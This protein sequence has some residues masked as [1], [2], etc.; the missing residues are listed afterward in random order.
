MTEENAPR[1]QD[2]ASSTHARTIAKALSVPDGT[3]GILRWMSENGH[4]DVQ[5]GGGAV[6]PNGNA[7]AHRRHSGTR[8]KA[9]RFLSFSVRIT[10]RRARA[11]V[12][13]RAEEILDLGKEAG[14]LGLG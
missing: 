3:A 12:G 10:P 14:G 9:W 13:A 11:L 1:R 4:K 8:D 5:G 6:K 7:A 2:G